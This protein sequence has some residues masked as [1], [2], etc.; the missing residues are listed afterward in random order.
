MDFQYIDDFFDLELLGTT[1]P[2]VAAQV[3]VLNGPG[4]FD[5]KFLEYL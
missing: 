3:K 1:K 4:Q 2:H 5:F